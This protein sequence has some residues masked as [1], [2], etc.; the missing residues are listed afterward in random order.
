MDGTERIEAA[1]AALRDAPEL[2][3]KRLRLGAGELIPVRRIELASILEE[4]WLARAL[5]P[6][7]SVGFGLE[8]LP[9]VDLWEH[10]LDPPS[11][12]QPCE[13]ALP[14]RAGLMSCPT[15]DAGGATCDDCGGAGRKW[16]W[17]GRH[18]TNWV[19][20]GTCQGRPI[21]C[22]FCTGTGLVE[23]TPIVKA[24]LRRTLRA[25]LLHDGTLPLEIAR[26]IA[27]APL[28]RARVIS[29]WQ[30]ETP[31]SLTG[32]A[33]GPYRGAESKVPADIA[34]PVTRLLDQMPLPDARWRHHRLQVTQ[35]E[36][37]RFAHRR[38]AIFVYADPPR[39]ALEGTLPRWPL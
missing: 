30:G 7:A 12:G 32:Q 5:R 6:A 37:V 39:V 14:E 9:A 13:L 24:R 8:P 27:A 19:I 29:T 28:A 10:V 18:D 4:R 1:R 33:G 31:D 23:A 22:S 35:G 11:D 15:C 16:L 2:M 21:P 17:V 38:G 25:E 36:I 20:C 34:E 3:G 26:E